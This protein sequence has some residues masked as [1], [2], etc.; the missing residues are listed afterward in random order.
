M[1]DLL[2]NAQDDLVLR[3]ALYHLANDPKFQLDDLE[4][5]LTKLMQRDQP[6]PIL[7]RSITRVVTTCTKRRRLEKPMI[8]V[9]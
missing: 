9:C 6:H 1:E 4:K 7:G 2:S 8:L 5:L 3:S